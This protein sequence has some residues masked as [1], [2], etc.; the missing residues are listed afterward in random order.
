MCPFQQKTCSSTPCVKL[1]IVGDATDSTNKD[2]CTFD[3]PK[4]KKACVLADKQ[5]DFDV[6]CGT[7]FYTVDISVTYSDATALGDNGLTWA[8]V[9][10][11]AMSPGYEDSA[12]WVSI[13][14]FSNHAI[15]TVGQRK[16]SI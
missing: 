9:K 8:E 10:R 16:T 5:E 14:S 6:P 15:R 7:D 4:V 2:G 1:G 11:E 13:L 3:N 12:Y